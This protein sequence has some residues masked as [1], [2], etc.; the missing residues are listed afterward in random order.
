[1]LSHFFFFSEDEDAPSP[2][3]RRL[4]SLNLLRR[5]SASSVRSTP[6]YSLS[7]SFSGSSV[8]EES[9]GWDNHDGGVRQRSI[10]L[11]SSSKHSTKSDHP[12][13]SWQKRT[14]T[15]S[16]RSSS[17][18]GSKNSLHLCIPE[19]PEH[20]I[21]RTGVVYDNTHIDTL[22]TP[23]TASSLSIPTPST[24]ADDPSSRKPTG[25]AV[26]KNKSLPPLPAPSLRKIPSKLSLT[27]TI[28]G[29][30]IRTISSTSVSRP[31]SPPTQPLPPVPTLNGSATPRPLKL[32]ETYRRQ[33]QS[34]P[35]TPVYRGGGLDRPPVPVPGVS[36]STSGLRALSTSTSNPALSSTTIPRTLPRP[37]SRLPSKSPTT[38]TSPTSPTSADLGKPKPRPRIGSGMVYRTSSYSGLDATTVAVASKLRIPKSLTLTSMNGQPSTTRSV[39]SSLPVMRPG[40]LRTPGI[41]RTIAS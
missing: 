26:D 30:R 8:P 36:Y 28:P 38:P 6:V 23:S 2:L 3:T 34:Q 18:A 40:A 1:M 33:S 10:T 25:I 24:P 14:Q 12:P 13:T 21:Q 32:P 7:R 27:S 29:T 19:Q 31:R 5:S 15:G 37:P 39:T 9:E 35:Q 16:H 20:E 41:P 22:N 11:S 17:S 4:S